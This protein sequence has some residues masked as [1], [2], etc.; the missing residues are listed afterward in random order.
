MTQSFEPKAASDTFSPV[1]PLMGK[2]L[3]LVHAFSV[4][5]DDARS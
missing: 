5:D 4:T 3:I 2:L 1:V